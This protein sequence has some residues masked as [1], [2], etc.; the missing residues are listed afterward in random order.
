M[1]IVETMRKSSTPEV[2]ISEPQKEEGRQGLS[3]QEAE[4]LNQRVNAVNLR[5]E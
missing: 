2:N 4:S 3:V 1:K 5:D